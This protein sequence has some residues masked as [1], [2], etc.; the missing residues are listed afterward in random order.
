MLKKF[1][2]GI[3][4][5]M[6]ISAQ[7]SAMRLE[8]YP[9][10]IG[11][12]SSDGEIFQIDGATKISGDTSKGTVLFGDKFYLQKDFGVP[13]HSTSQGDEIYGGKIYFHFD[14][15]KIYNRFGELNIKNTVSVDT[16]GE[17]EIYLITNTAGEDLF[18]LKKLQERDDNIKILGK[19]GGHWIE[20]LNAL[21][22]RQKHNIGQ[23]FHMSKFFTEDNKIIFRYTLRE[24]VIDVI[25]S[26]HAVNEKFYTETREQ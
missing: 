16:Y 8:L 4:L 7:A 17:A 22:F 23:N 24:H 15:E 5:L 18:L 14:A 1:F 21:D 9:Q 19:R 20:Q 6:I 12:I 2:A 13:K 11:K 3:F 10:P 26:Y 25:C